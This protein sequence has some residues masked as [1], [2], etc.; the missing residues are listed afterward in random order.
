MTS[1][2]FEIERS[3]R[4]NYYYISIVT[5]RVYFLPVFNMLQEGEDRPMDLEKN[6]DS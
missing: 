4:N 3:Y 5:E 6:T 2:T 1:N